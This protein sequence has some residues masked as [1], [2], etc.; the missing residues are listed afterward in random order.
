MLKDWLLVFLGGGVGCLLRYGLARWLNA[1]GQLFAWGTWGANVAACLL[2]GF[3]S[4]W[5]S[6][7]A[8]A[9]WLRPLVMVG[10]CGG[11]STFST[12][13]NESLGLLQ[14]QQY[15]AFGGYVL[16]SLLVCLL[17]VAGGFAAGRWLLA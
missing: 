17:A 13:S 2:L 14:Q 4:Y 15:A 11:F 3:F 12:F 16:A 8:G 5:V 6:L 7:K 9:E 1:E 10:L